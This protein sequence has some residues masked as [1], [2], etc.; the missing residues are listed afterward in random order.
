MDGLSGCRVGYSG[1]SPQLL[2]LNHQHEV[3][4]DQREGVE[5]FVDKNRSRVGLGLTTGIYIGV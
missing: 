5:S 4:M 2:T 1:T 3:E